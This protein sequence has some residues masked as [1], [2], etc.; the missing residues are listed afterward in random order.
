MAGVVD[1]PQDFFREG[2]ATIAC[3][4]RAAAHQQVPSNVLLAL[5]SVEGGKNR[6]AVR[7]SNGSYDLGHFQINTIHLGRFSG[8]GISRYDIQNRGCYNAL[9]AAW[10]LREKLSENNDQDFWTRAAN[11]HSKTPVYNRR[12]RA[13]LVKMA[14]KWGHWLSKEYNAVTVTFK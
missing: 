13:K 1:L 5:A 3:V 9:L 6:Q 2:P 12:Y 7:N 10:M 11:Y 14:E 4:V 8:F